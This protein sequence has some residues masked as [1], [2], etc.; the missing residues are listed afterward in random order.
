[1]AAGAG[2]VFA[3][4][5]DGDGDID[6]VSAS[7]NDDKVAW[8]ENTDGAGTFGPQQ[9][10]SMLAAGAWSVFAMDVDGDGDADVLSASPFDD[11][12]AWYENTDGAGTF[13]PQQIIST[14]GDA[15]KS[16][17]ATDVD[18]D[19][20]TDVLAAS[21]NDSEIAWYEN[22]DGAGNFG[23]RHL[24]STQTLGA[25]SIFATDVNG[26]G[27]SDVLAAAFADEA[28]WYEQ[29]NVAD[30]LD[31]DTDDDGLSDGDEVNIHG[32]NP[33]TPDTDSDGLTDLFEVNHGFN[34]TTGGDATQDPDGD[35]IDNLSEQA[36]GTDPN[37]ADSDDDGLLDG[38]EV[39]HAFNPLAP[40]EASQDPDADGLNNLAEQTA[41]TNPH[42]SDSDDDGL[43]DGV[44]VNTYGTSPVLADS[45]DDGL[46]DG[47][48]VNTYGTSP[49]HADS[50]GDGLSDGQEVNTYGTSP[51]NPDTDG[52]T[53]VD[54]FEVAHG[55]NP[56]VADYDPGYTEVVSRATSG[57][58]GNNQ[59][60]EPSISSDGRFVAFRSSATNLDP[61]DPDGDG[62][63]YV[64]DLQIGT[65]T[66][67]SRAS[68]V[69]G[70]KGN[71]DSVGPSISSDGRFVAFESF[72]SN[73]DPVD[74]GLNY[75]IYVRDLQTNTTT[76]VSRASGVAGAKGNEAS[77]DPS[78]SSDGRFVAFWS[79]AT[80]L[81]PADPSLNSADVYV[82]DLQT[83]TT[84]LVSRASGV[85]GAK[86]N[87]DSARS[88]DLVRRPLRRVLVGGSQPRPGRRRYD[89]DVYVR[90]LQTGT[91]T[92]VSRASG[93]SGAKG[94]FGSVRAV[95]LVRRPLRC[96]LLGG[97][98]TSI[99]AR[100]R[101]DRRRLRPRP[102]RP[103]RRRW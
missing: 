56:L 79:Y 94:N 51:N 57:A 95:D 20:D 85:A 4:D 15:V 47:V 90:D 26:D 59:S 3:T 91:T 16:V 38:F 27:A 7:V 37:D 103:G 22:L 5:V 67:V 17:F 89:G 33:Q 83:G 43:D 76:L 66:L 84:T 87:E 41:S 74:P 102:R 65:T 45:D 80:N 19:G 78:I 101:Y 77:L 97:E 73:L 100:P 62:D 18:G 21:G 96:V 53:L 23:S 52:D 2:S 48:E 98:P 39:A 28:A 30:P 50:D 9:V 88:V 46:D 10:I 49:V 93:V 71:F 86:G 69:S 8:Y 92:L 11:K 64:R 70:A 25:W 60:S 14:Q 54:G 68:G 58:K 31:P 40:G 72:A 32:T 44:E 29:L 36:A 34:P 81:D 1:M 12:V 13:G 42:D 61:A 6:V 55:F 75:D 35:G 99:P 63:I 82:R 24:I